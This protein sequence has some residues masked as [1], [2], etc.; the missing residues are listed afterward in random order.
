MR[1]S[2]WHRGA[3]VA[4][5]LLA[6][7]GQLIQ[8]LVSPV[9]PGDSAAEQVA[10]AAAHTGAMRLA[11][12]LD[13]P[14]LLV[15]PAVLYAGLVAGRSRLA[16]AGTALTFGTALGAGYLLG[17]DIVVQ[18][19]AGQADR[20]G[21][22][23]LVEG[24]ATSGVLTGLV[25][26]YLVGHVVG[27]ILL[28]IALIRSRAVPAWAGVALSVWPLAEMGGQAAGVR[29]VAAAGFV[30][31]LAGFAA[32]AVRLVQGGRPA[33]SDRVPEPVGAIG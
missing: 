25:A 33:G 17:Q 7:L 5:L 24:Y 29:V 27:F 14:I 20:A 8:F 18:V 19:A 1:T 15:L 11:V 31:L 2:L 30:L 4:C 22:V 32:C 10:A 16:T 12:V 13:L 21:A 9:G 26:L 28:G 3:G 6:P 23:A